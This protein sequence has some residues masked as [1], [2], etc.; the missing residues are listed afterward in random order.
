MKASEKMGNAT[1][2]IPLPVSAPLSPYLQAVLTAKTGLKTV[3]QESNN[4]IAL[5][6]LFKGRRKP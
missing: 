4:A 5:E 3:V 2:V 6:R 1:T